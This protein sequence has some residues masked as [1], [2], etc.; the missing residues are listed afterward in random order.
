[1]ST[2]DTAK[3]TAIIGLFGLAIEALLELIKYLKDV[4]NE[5]LDEARDKVKSDHR[6]DGDAVEEQLEAY[7]K[8]LESYKR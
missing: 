7:K 4:L 3:T 2:K 5:D 6:I 1:M 8:K